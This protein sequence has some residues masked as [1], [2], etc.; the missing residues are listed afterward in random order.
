MPTEHRLH[1]QHPA[2]PRMRLALR[3]GI[4]SLVGGAAILGVKFVAWFVTGSTAVLADAAEQCVNVVA[5]MLVVFSVAVASRPPDADHPYGHGKAEFLSAAVEGGMIVVAGTFILIEAIRQMVIGPELHR[6]GTGILIAGAGG[7]ANLTLGLYLV[8][9]GRRERSS[10]VEADGVHCLSDVWIT[11]GSVAALV[12]VRFTG[13]VYLDPLVALVVGV[14]VLRMGSKVVRRALG[15]LLDKADFGLLE[16]I[17]EHLEKIRR[18]E[19]VEIHQLR[20]WSSGWVTHLDLHLTVPRYF[21]IADAHRE[22]DELE[23]ELLQAVAGPGDVVVHIDPCLPDQCSACTVSECP[24]R[25]EALEKRLEFSVDK[26][27]RAGTI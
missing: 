7:I 5:S 3:A 10:A 4:I 16:S 2:A 20:T 19:W 25:G 8:R 18:P 23:A 1:E 26:L 14:H 12:G 21:S 6:V 27:T 11:V 13:W 15:G 17:A 22:A 24:V 9:V